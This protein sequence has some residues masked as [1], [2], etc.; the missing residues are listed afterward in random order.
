MRDSLGAWAASAAHTPSGGQGIDLTE[1]RA[2]NTAAIERLEQASAAH[3]A[4]AK[5][6]ATAQAEGQAAASEAQAKA[7]VTDSAVPT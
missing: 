1:A 6:L 7:F 4:A 2:A 3:L 5:M